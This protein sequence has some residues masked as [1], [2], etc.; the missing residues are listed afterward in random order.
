[1]TRIAVIADSHIPERAR[2]IPGAFESEIAS[3]DRVVH[4]GDFTSA[5]ALERVE[6]LAGGPLTAVSGNMDPRSIDL[7]AVDRLSVEDVTF[8]VTHGTG[9]PR[10]Y[11]ERVATIV[12]EHAGE[13][14]GETVVGIAGHTHEVLDTIVD[15]IRLLNPGSVTGA[16]PASEATML[17]VDVD[18]SDLSVAV[19]E[20]P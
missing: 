18:G 1:M 2:T 12:R 4:A 10:G 9:S 14:T 16:A 17:T 6:S 13:S 3:A 8:V 11:E 20:Q 19:H 7:P 5:E 15:G